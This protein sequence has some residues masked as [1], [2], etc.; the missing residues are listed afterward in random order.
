MNWYYTVS[1]K[2]VGPMTEATLDDLF[3]KG[4]V[5]P[6][7]LVWQPGLEGWQPYQ[8]AKTAVVG[9][10]AVATRAGPAGPD[11]APPPPPPPAAPKV[12]E[13][14][15]A[16][17][18]CGAVL[19]TF[20]LVRHEGGWRCRACD[21]N[22]RQE[23]EAGELAP[24]RYR[25]NRAGFWR[26]VPPKLIDLALLAALAGGAAFASAFLGGGTRV[27]QIAAAVVP[28]GF[29]TVVTGASGTTPGKRLFALWIVTPAGYPVGFLRAGWRL[30]CE[31]LG[32]GVG[33]ASVVWSQGR[34][35][36]AEAAGQAP[37]WLAIVPLWLL[38]YAVVL[39]NPAKRALHD[40]LAGTCVIRS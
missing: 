33:V 37:L 7:T 6:D 27:M 5:L 35:E 29:F 28:L 40:Y 13:S 21:L 1:G 17:T 18:E 36:L 8:R 10:N 16:C 3:A 26:R 32:F 14:L 20:K 12:G 4:E 9:S 23:A 15:G 38:T 22:V 39:V 24:S 25:G 19:P 34:P 2:T 30:V 11:R 31:W